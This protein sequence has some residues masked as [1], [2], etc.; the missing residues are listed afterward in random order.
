[1]CLDVGIAWRTGLIWAVNS[2]CGCAWF[3]PC[4]AWRLCEQGVVLWCNSDGPW[5]WQVLALHLLVLVVHCS[6]RFTQSCCALAGEGA[7]A[8]LKEN[9]FCKIFL[10]DLLAWVRG[11]TYLGWK[12][13]SWE[14]RGN[15]WSWCWCCLLWNHSS[16]CCARNQSFSAHLHI[17]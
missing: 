10:L 6:S 15:S 14:W 11:C 5:V 8:L 3:L 13:A 17:Y 2:L 16:E 12:E 1:M 4:A 9:T 7:G